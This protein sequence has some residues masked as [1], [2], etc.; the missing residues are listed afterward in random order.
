MHAHSIVWFGLLLLAV[1]RFFRMLLP[2]R[3]VAIAG[4][5]YAVSYVHAVP[6]GWIS[7]RNALVAG[8]F[9]FLAIAAYMR[10]RTSSS[11]APWAP[12]LLLVSLLS[13][14]S[15]VSVL[16]FV[17]GFEL[18]L[19][20]DSPEGRWLR[21][22]AMLLVVAL[23]RAGYSE[24]G[25]GAVGSGAYIDPVRSPVVFLREA[26]VRMGMLVVFLLS[27][28]RLL[29]AHG[30]STAALY[31][32]AVLFA[33]G[34][35][36]V[37]W[38]AFRRGA[39]FWSVSAA[40][41]LLPLLAAAPG[42]RLLT[43]AAAAV[44]PVVAAVLHDAWSAQTWKRVAAAPLTVSF[45]VVS[46]LVLLV[47]S[48]DQSYDR[49]AAPKTEPTMAGLSSEEVR[50]K[51]LFILHAPDQASVN[52]MRLSRARADLALPAFVWNLFPTDDPAHVKR[53]GCCTLEL[54]HDVGLSRA[55][56]V[57]YYRGV[58]SPM[59]VGETVKTLAFTAE[60]LSVSSSGVPTGVRFTFPERLE[61]PRNLFVAWT[62]AD[63]AQV[64][65]PGA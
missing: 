41:C 58:D 4:A 46:P 9:G 15:G 63:F 26:P 38:G 21:L 18:T 35:V 48:Y 23:W 12:A 20:R 51:N 34:G 29:V 32:L 3:L 43:F 13:A 19:G 40:L 55:P 56:F 22:G 28:A 25:F 31:S 7:N 27:P 11:R 65:V 57:L 54:R 53:V 39:R 60:V 47:A 17:V 5:L 36:A 64:H 14:E 61:S 62:G 30:L 8:V 52:M 33:A 6:V 42:E 37:V 24:G 16:A 10:W 45:G 2:Q 1:L 50:G 49:R 44:T 59:R